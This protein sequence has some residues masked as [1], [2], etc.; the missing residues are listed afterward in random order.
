M[1]KRL[2]LIMTRFYRY[3]LMGLGGQA[4]CY[5]AKGFF[6]AYFDIT[7]REEI[8]DC[9]AGLAIASE[10]GAKITNLKGEYPGINASHL[11]VTNGK[12]HEELLELMNG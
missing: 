4:M 3:R 12:I 11:V 9:G 8:V 10:A 2:Q 5:L 7:G 6:D 1:F